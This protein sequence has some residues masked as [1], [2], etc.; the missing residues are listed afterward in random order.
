M[1]TRLSSGNLTPAQRE[2]REPRRPQLLLAEARFR[3]GQRLLPMAVICLDFVRLW[4][5]TFAY[6][7]VADAEHPSR[8][9]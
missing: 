1:M 3:L 2:R 9:R 4:M 6:R 8:H 7:Q 5:F